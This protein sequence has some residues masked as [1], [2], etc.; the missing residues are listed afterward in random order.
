MCG[1][2]FRRHTALLFHI[3]RNHAALDC[4]ANGPHNHIRSKDECVGPHNDILS[5]DEGVA[6]LLNDRDDRSEEALQSNPT[7]S[8]LMLQRKLVARSTPGSLPPFLVNKVYDV[9]TEKREDSNWIDYLDVYYVMNK[10]AMS[11]TDADEM[12]RTFFRILLRKDMHTILP[13]SC[14]VIKKAVQKAVMSHFTYVTFNFRLPNEWFTEQYAAMK[15]VA[16]GHF[17]T[18]IEVLAEMLI[19]IPVQSFNFSPKELRNENG[20]RI[21][22]EP[23]TGH[24][25]KEYCK[26]VKDKCGEDVYPLAIVVNGDSLILNKTGEQ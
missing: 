4:I 15:S 10:T 16:S 1:E 8:L 17:V 19:E 18:L 21:L 9:I 5:E 24:V 12:L 20:E 7:N 13:K 3:K 23:A 22:R 14:R 26:F 6:G 25:F 11:M 2:S